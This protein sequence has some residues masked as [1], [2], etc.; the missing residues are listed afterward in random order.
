MAPPQPRKAKNVI[1]SADVKEYAS[2]DSVERPDECENNELARIAKKAVVA[3]F[4]VLCISA[5][6][7]MD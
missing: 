5:V 6:T 3:S 1:R 7:W 2:T 4:K